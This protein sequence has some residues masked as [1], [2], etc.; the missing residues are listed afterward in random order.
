MSCADFI[1]MLFLARDVTHSAHLNTRSYAKHKAL[2]KFY[3]NIVP[4]AD[5]LAE[6]YQGKYGLIGPITLMSAK[7]T[8]NVVA[9][10]EDQVDDLMEMRYKAVDKECTPLQNIIDEIFGLYYTT[11]YKL[12]FLA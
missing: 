6:A 3:T 11:L 1:G 10:L 12:K 7:K 8:N 4:L 9:F 2:G 5:K